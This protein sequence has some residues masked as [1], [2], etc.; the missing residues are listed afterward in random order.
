MNSKD[1][2]PKG[3][4]SAGTPEDGNDPLLVEQRRL[5]R[6]GRLHWLHWLVIA[7]S[8][9][10]TLLAWHYSRSALET[11]TRQRFD[12]HAT[13]AIEL[14]AEKLHTHADLLRASAGLLEASEEVTHEEWRRYTDALSLSE[15]F[16]AISGLGVIYRVPR[17]SA[18]T[19]VDEHR[20]AYPEFDLHPVHT[21]PL[22]L[23]LSLIAPRALEKRVLGFDLAHDRVRRET[24]MEAMRSGTVQITAPIKLTGRDGLGVLMVTP[25]GESADL[26]RRGGVAVASMGPAEL[27][28]GTLA[29]GRRQVVL[30]V[31]DGGM[32]L[33]DEHGGPSATSDEPTHAL[34]RQM[35]L[36]GRVWDFDVRS[37]SAFDEASASLMP[38]LILVGGLGLEGLLLTL[39][40]ALSRANRQG[41]SFA[42]RLTVQLR[43]KRVELEASNCTLKAFAYAASHDLK[44]PLY[45]IGTLAEFIEE[46]LEELVAG[47]DVTDALPNIRHN[48]DRIRQQVRRSQLLVDGILQYSV[49]EHGDECQTSVNTR[50]LVEDIGESLRTSSGRI[51]L[52][53]DFPVLL[54]DETRLS[55]VFANLIGNAFKYHHDVAS[56]RVVVRAEPM[57][58]G[59]H[60]FSVEDDGPGIEAAYHERIFELFQT[61]GSVPGV[62][63]TGV[64]LSIVKKAIEGQGGSISVDSVPGR[65]TTFTFDWPATVD[66]DASE[67]NSSTVL[68]KAA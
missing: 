65:G 32:V 14:F 63:S 4:C 19:F 10:L 11:Q 1:A 25:F 6:R 56:A 40:V 20:E 15:Q 54:T 34:S 44:T 28:Y 21:E 58:E 39:F 38:T 49:L 57:D 23:P 45:G 22:H 17:E 67:D 36:Y 30:R 42:N 29:A 13:D 3:S 50:A 68:R 43:A 12:V 61:L 51:V 8:G 5:E 64:G 18:A 60:R 66:S 55:Q 33:H 31:S 16:P 7:L 27:A 26:R 59:L 24:I 53:G 48:A 35:S 41:L 2:V 52:E 37:T 47:G 46:D 9:A 62:D